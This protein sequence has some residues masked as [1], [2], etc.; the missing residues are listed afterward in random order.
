MNKEIQEIINKECVKYNRHLQIPGIYKHF[1]EIKD[2]EEMLY[3]VTN[4]SIPVDKDEFNKIVVATCNGFYMM[5]H[6]ELELKIPIARIGDKYYHNKEVEKEMLVMY[7]GLYGPRESY[8][9][10]LPMFLSRTDKEKYPNATQKY[11]LELI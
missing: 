8:L 1:K 6:T 11:R 3:I 9:R 7:T 4:V 5:H 10:P 2:N